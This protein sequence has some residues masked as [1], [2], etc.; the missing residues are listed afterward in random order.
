[1][2]GAIR[3][4]AHAALSMIVGDEYPLVGVRRERIEQAR[5]ALAS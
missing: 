3:R 4:P 2:P 5:K 1:L